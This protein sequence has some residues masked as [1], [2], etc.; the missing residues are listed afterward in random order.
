[1]GGNV[2]WIWLLKKNARE[3]EVSLPSVA[4]ILA[5]VQKRDIKWSFFMSKNGHSRHFRG[6][7]F[8]LRCHHTFFSHCAEGNS[9]RM[10][11]NDRVQE[12]SQ[13]R[14]LFC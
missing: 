8:F 4:K 7:H 3:I 5:T 13:D 9:E 10:M 11:R 1:M 12:S 6:D 2:G 14:Y